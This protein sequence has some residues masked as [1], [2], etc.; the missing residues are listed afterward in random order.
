MQPIAL[1]V[2]ILFVVSLAIS[3]TSPTSEKTKIKAYFSDEIKKIPLVQ[4]G[5]IMVSYAQIA[6]FKN[7]LTYSYNNFLSD[8]MEVYDF[9]AD[10]LL[11][12]VPY[13][14]EGPDGV[15]RGNYYIA[16]DYITIKGAYEQVFFDF[17]GK[18]IKRYRLLNKEGRKDSQVEIPYSEYWLR[19]SSNSRGISKYFDTRSEKAYLGLVR[20][21]VALMSESF[22]DAPTII[23]EIDH[24]SNTIRSLPITFPEDFRQYQQFGAAAIDFILPFILIKGDSLIYNFSGSADIYIYDITKQKMA[25]T[26]RAPSSYMPPKIDVTLPRSGSHIS[27]LQNQQPNFGHI[28]YDPYRN[29]Y[30][31]V[32]FA[33]VEDDDYWSRVRYF[34]IMDAHFS[35]LQEVPLTQ[36]CSSTIYGPAPEGVY[37]KQRN[38]PSEDT[39]YFKLLRI[40]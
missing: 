10:T 19:L 40:E 23:G 18:V 34:T 29:Y 35:V 12:T 2:Q 3:C 37:F 31:R 8:R 27:Y 16:D 13:K 20:Q 6:P 15:P 25:S 39:T 17:G 33:P 5:T 7:Y 21:D 11:F 30:Y 38:P 26:V 1:F 4:G 9:Q 14:E 32:N 24:K 22:F 28:T 36:D